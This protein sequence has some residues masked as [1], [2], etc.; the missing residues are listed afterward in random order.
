V[1]SGD[2]VKISITDTGTGIDEHTLKRIFEPFFTTKSEEGG[3]GL[4]LASAY[5]IIRNHGGIINAY[6]EQGRG[7]T[8]NIL[9]P[10]S[11]KSALKDNKKQ[12]DKALQPG[13]GTILLIDDEPIIMNIVSE[14]LKVLGYFV[15]NATDEQ[16]AVSV[17]SEK[18]DV[19][20]LVILDMILRGT[21]GAQVLK[22]LREINPA[23]R[24]I[25]SSGYSLQGEVE[26]VMEMGCLGFIQKPYNFN[27]ISAIIHKVLAHDS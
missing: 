3:T 9:L 26:K 23:V 18:K 20:D 19:I 25:L 24:V 17:Y 14:M 1:K 22:K 5:G 7:T 8:F 13:S 16:E 11:G 10:A 4:G 21:S 6:S 12:P 27:E 2:Y 15:Y